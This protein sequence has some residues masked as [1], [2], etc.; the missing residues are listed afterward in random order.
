MRSARRSAWTR[1]STTDRDRARSGRDDDEHDEPE[2][3]RDA[4]DREAHRETRVGV[5]ELPLAHRAVD[6]R[7]ATLAVADADDAEHRE[8]DA[9]DGV[10]PL[11]LAARELGHDPRR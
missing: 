7:A 2:P 3:E 4:G 8:G 9:D 6:A 10:G 11:D 5:H 1:T